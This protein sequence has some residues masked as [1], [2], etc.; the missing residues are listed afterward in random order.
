MNNNTMLFSAFLWRESIRQTWPNFRSH[1]QDPKE[2]LIVL[3]HSEVTYTVSDPWVFKNFPEQLLIRPFFVHQAWKI[4]TLN[5]PRHIP[6]VIW[7]QII[8]LREAGLKFKQFSCRLFN[9]KLQYCRKEIQRNGLLRLQKSWM[10]EM[11]DKIGEVFRR[12]EGWVTRN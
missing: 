6:T 11:K 5:M 3:F 12:I 8:A 10:R 7:A 9:W 1:R 2:T 4:Q